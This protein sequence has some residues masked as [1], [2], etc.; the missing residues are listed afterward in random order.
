MQAKI[1][2]VNCGQRLWGQLVDFDQGA[3]GTVGVLVD[4]SDQ[5]Q[6]PMGEHFLDFERRAGVCTDRCV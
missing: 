5:W 2:L 3:S 1:R 4:K 6:G